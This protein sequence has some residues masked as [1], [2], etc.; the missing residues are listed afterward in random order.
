[1]FPLREFGR[2]PS[3]TFLNRKIYTGKNMFLFHCTTCFSSENLLFLW[4]KFG[5]KIQF[6]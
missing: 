5:K 2:V 4:E 3:T 6:C 1:V